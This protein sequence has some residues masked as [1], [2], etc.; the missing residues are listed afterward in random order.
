M[1]KSFPKVKS[2]KAWAVI[3]F[4]K[5]I[6]IFHFDYDGNSHFSIFPSKEEAKA[7]SADRF[8]IIPVLITPI[9][10]PNKNG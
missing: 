6:Q 10:K 5:E 9:I 4:E 2:I 3:E 8:P 1:T 7:W